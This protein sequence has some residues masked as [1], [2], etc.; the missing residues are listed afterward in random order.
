MPAPPEP[1]QDEQPPQA[2]QAEMPIE[3][4]PLALVAP[5][6]VPMPEAT[7]STPPTTSEAPPIVPATSAPPPSESSIS[8]S[9]LEFRGPCHTLQTLSTTQGVLFHPSK[10]IAPS[11]EA[12]LAE[13]TMPHEETTTVE[14]ETPIQST[15]ETTVEP[16]S[17]HDPST[18]T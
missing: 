2:Q 10:L 13:Q 8:I 14:D 4:V 3:I 9:S 18:T 12:T 5:S 7:S 6:I 17:S 16:S 1:L 11:E 15:Q